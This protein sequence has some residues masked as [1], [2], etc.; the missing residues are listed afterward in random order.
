MSFHH[1]L[2]VL[3]DDPD[4][5]RMV[6]GDAVRLAEADRAR[7]TLAKTTDPGRVVRWLRPCAALS[8]L[9]PMAEMLSAEADMK[10]IAGHRLARAAEFV[11]ASIPITTILLGPRTGSALRVLVKGGSYDLVV[12]GAALL[13]RN[14]RLSRDLRRLGVCAPALSRPS[15]P[16]T[17]RS[18]E[19]SP[20]AR[21]AAQAGEPPDFLTEPETIGAL[22]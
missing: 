17:D 5:I 10:A 14:R 11:P 7:L 6:L 12:A 8:V 4:E 2:G 20:G 21:S 13:A 1:V 19:P 3:D 16:A 22:T 9:V 18:D 15:P